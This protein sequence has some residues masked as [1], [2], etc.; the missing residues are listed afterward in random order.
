MKVMTVSD[1]M[2]QNV[3]LTPATKPQPKP[4]PGE[5]LI[6]VRAAGVTPTELLWHPTSHTKDDAMRVEPVPC[7]EFSGV[8]EAVGPGVEN[9]RPGQQIYGMNDWFSDGAL[10]EYCVAPATSV[11]DKPRSLNFV[12]AAS[13]PIAALTA[14]Q[15]LID[16][17]GVQAGERV[18]VHGGAGSV[19]V[20]AVQLAHLRHAEVIAT[21]S[22]HNLDFVASLGAA[23]VI[24]YRA[25]RF[26]DL[27]GQV[28]V[29]FDTVGGDTLDRSW[30]LLKPNGRLVTV[31]TGADR[32]SDKRV[33]DAFFIVEANQ[34]KLAVIGDI[35]D[36]GRLRP[37]VDAVCPPSRAAEAFAGLPERSGRGK[38]VIAPLEQD[39][40]WSAE[41]TRLATA[42]SA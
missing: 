37:V 1:V 8:V 31:A 11:A 39:S 22:A 3:R 27:A 17:S 29:V 28:D 23:Q 24:D 2:Q 19:G 32:S 16:R 13:V 34:G 10:A 30:P 5:V 25:F 12:E 26:E 40:A 33:R 9:M 18:L 7:H 4:G 42:E 36:E 38:I 20:F 14:W 15:G 35:I 6:S 41:V 21:A